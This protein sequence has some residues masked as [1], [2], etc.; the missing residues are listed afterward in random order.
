MSVPSPSAVPRA[1]RTLR[2][3]FTRVLLLA[4]ILPALLFGGVLLWSQARLERVQLGERLAISARLTGAAL[5]DITEA[6]M[7][8]V[9][10]LADRAAERSPDWPRALAQLQQR[11]PLFA[12]VLL[13]DGDGNVVI[14]VPAPP[15]QQPRNFVGDREYFRSVRAGQEPHVSDA[16]RGRVLSSKPLV[17]VS[18]PVL[19]AGGFA[20]VVSASIRI[21]D[22]MGVRAQGLRRRGYEVLLADR[23]G[24]VV[25]ASPGMAY[26]FLGPVAPALAQLPSVSTGF[27]KAVVERTG[28]LRNGDV[29]YVARNHLRNGW[30]LYLLAPRGQLLHWL[31]QRAL[32]M[33]G[34]VV[35]LAAGVL[36]ASWWQAR[37]LSRGI[38]RLLD[39]LSAFAL[40]GA[41]DLRRVQAMPQELQPLAGAI[42]DLSHRL[43]ET[44]DEL[45][46]SLLRQ[47]ELSASLRSVV[48]A[49]E[50]EIAQRTGELRGAVAE[51]DRLS[52]TDALTGC[53]NYR[54]F[55]ETLQRLWADARAH[56]APLSVLA[57]D[58]DRF[59]AYNDRY[60]HQR[61]DNALKRF[62]GAVRSALFSPED[63]LARQGGEEFLVFLPGTTLEQAVQVGERIVA[64][65]AAAGIPHADSPEGVLTVSAGAATVLP[66]SDA[67]DLLKRADAALYR[68]K[69]AGRNRVSD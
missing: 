48:D 63:V 62:A 35:L 9:S 45:N 67:E 29:A 21:E 13:T 16:F 43:N 57:L 5:D 12:S 10:L 53:L 38:A 11:F 30:D 23:G 39:T 69:R 32:L 7:A 1:S 20:G 58:I 55:D 15:P 34:L 44:Y 65:V 36:A 68:A 17:A 61:G 6:H 19:D 56:G 47:S 52:R 50:R 4:A 3:E 14:S 41:L 18:A 24:H 51:L 26:R 25:F 59:K 60:G 54:G 46:V 28:M 40:G 22:L 31:E 66:D 27:D 8:G 37:L 49:R 64:S 33:V 42:G 2:A